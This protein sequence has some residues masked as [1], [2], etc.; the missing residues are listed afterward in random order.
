[1]K[2]RHRLPLKVNESDTAFAPLP[3]GVDFRFCGAERW[4]QDFKERNRAGNNRTRQDEATRAW[5]LHTALY[6]KSGG[7][8]WRLPRRDSDLATCYVGIAFYW[9]R[10]EGVLDTS[11]AQIFNERGGGMIVRG[12]KA[13]IL[14]DDR[15]LH[16]TEDDS[17]ELLEAVLKRYRTEHRTAPAR[18]V[19]HK[20]SAYR[21]AELAGF[22][23]AADNQ[24]ISLLEPLWL[25]RSA[26][27]RFFRTEAFP[28]LRGPLLSLSEDRHLLYTRGSVLTYRTYPGMYVRRPLGFR[29]ID[30]ETGSAELA[31]ELLAL[32]KM[33][34]NTTP[35][36][37]YQPITLRTA[38]TVGDILRHLDT[39]EHPAGR[40][41]FYM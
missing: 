30:P 5:N 1:M 40:Y 14:K 18:V 17:F 33:N 27:T 41:A 36:D 10:D 7:V 24:R 38:D 11:V 8:P 13:A 15:Q 3:V 19:M 25:T 16:L 22:R 6:Y 35:L 31:A 9:V 29:H 2:T 4:D 12:G 28:P 21:D 23:S 20:T 26:P 39:D 34:W 37:G 32:T